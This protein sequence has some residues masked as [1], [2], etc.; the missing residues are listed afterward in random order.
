VHAL[1]VHLV[2]VTKYRRGVFTAEA[3]EVVRASL[4]GV[5]KDFS[6]T[7]RDF[8]GEDDHVH[9]VVDYPPTVQL[10]KLVNS[11]KGVSSRRLRARRFPEVTSRLWG[12]HLCSPSYFAASCGGVTLEVLKRYIEGLS[13]VMAKDDR[14]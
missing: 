9:L 2:F 11:L 3:L 7:L 5:Y 6:C 1:Q 4:V 12:G 8:G 14:T 10:T 13:T